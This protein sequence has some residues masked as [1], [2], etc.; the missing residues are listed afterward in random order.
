MVY[1]EQKKKLFW[2]AGSYFSP[3][4]SDETERS[5][6]MTDKAFSR[7]ITLLFILITMMSILQSTWKWH[8]LKKN[9]TWR[10][11]WAL[12]VKST[13]PLPTY[14]YYFPLQVSCDF[15][16]LT[17]IL[18]EIWIII[19]YFRSSPDRQTESDAYEPT[20]QLAQVG[21]KNER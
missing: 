12:P 19:S 8:G 6:L 3:L 18:S 20:V 17:P 4:G 2:Q 13:S 14:V 15:R 9:A 11:Q 7:N 16:F 1:S 5:L 21:S 10:W